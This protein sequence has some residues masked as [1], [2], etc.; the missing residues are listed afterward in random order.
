MPK[1]KRSAGKSALEGMSGGILLIGI[2]VLF[3]WDAIP[4]WPWIL[5]VIGLSGLP[6]SIANE[7]LW[8]GMQGFVWMAGIALLFAGP[9]P[10]WPGI[11]IVIGISTMAGALFQPPA[12]K[13][14][15]RASTIR[16]GMGRLPDDE[17]DDYA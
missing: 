1:Q 6:G 5:V 2:G 12:L 10:F 9:I 3:L 15:K 11:L 4:F 8:A 14:R 13:K 17:Y 16:A 7:G